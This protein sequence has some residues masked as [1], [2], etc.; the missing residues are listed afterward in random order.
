MVGAVRAFR[1]KGDSTH[2]AKMPGARSKRVS[3][4]VQGCPWAGCR[5]GGR[6]KEHR[7]GQRQRIRELGARRAAVAGSSTSGSGSHGPTYDSR[8]AGADFGTLIESRV[9][10]VVVHAAGSS[11]GPCW[12]VRRNSASWA[13]SS[14]YET[15]PSIR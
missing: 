5:C 1:A 2:T 13:T 14:A 11:I 4:D 7:Q 9:T 12:R 3:A 6:R 15:L 8:R 10:T